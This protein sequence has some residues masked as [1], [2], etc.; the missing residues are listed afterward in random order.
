MIR[1]S[2]LTALDITST[3]FVEDM[4]MQK[5]HIY[6]EPGLILEKSKLFVKAD[7][8]KLPQMS[9]NNA[10]ASFFDNV[11]LGTSNFYPE[12]GLNLLNYHSKSEIQKL[13]QF[14]DVPLMQYKRAYLYFAQGALSASNIV[15]HYIRIYA[16]QENG[17][18]VDLVSLVEFMNDSNIKAKTSKLFENQIFNEALEITFP[19]IEYI[20]NS[21][22]VEV[23]KIREY[24]FGTSTPKT[25]FIEYSALTSDMIDNFSENGLQFTEINLA[26]VNYQNY[27]ITEESDELFSRLQLSNND[28]AIT[29]SLGH[30]SYDIETFIKNQYQINDE[31]FDISHIVSITEYDGLDNVINSSIQM[32]S[33]P[34]DL[35]A[36]Q[37]VR[38]LLSEL[39]N[40]ALIEVMIKIS[41]G[42]TGLT[43]S[44]SSSMILTEEQ[45][46]KF[47]PQSTFELSFEKVEVR[48]IVEK[49]INKIVQESTTPKLLY[50]NKLVY[51]QVQSSKDLFIV[52]GDSYVKIKND[53]HQL[54]TSTEELQITSKKL[55]L[56]IGNNVIENEVSDKFTFKLP[57]SIF[58]DKASNYLLLDD[59]MLVIQQGQ[60][61]KQ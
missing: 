34:S 57:Q 24:L 41:N 11:L 33:N 44:K 31:S 39:T 8:Y 49:K 18:T 14:D 16:M 38:P 52:N 4:S 43:I 20:V 15:A 13:I 3:E 55:F 37:E 40:H 36:P 21:T 58:F 2:N 61:F 22:N 7:T 59:D 35:Y 28:F 27:K 48:N 42:A 9:R 19:D 12:Q 51:V 25:Y 60:I 46:E 10:V 23:M 53:I 54:Q 26:T 47:K 30:T 50:V 1:L 17:K 29:S 5:L 56:K 6:E 45:V 32:L